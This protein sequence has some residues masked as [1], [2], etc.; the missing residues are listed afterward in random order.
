[1]P[2]VRLHPQYLFRLRGRLLESFSHPRTG[3]PWLID[4]G[5]YPTYTPFSRRASVMESR[6][7]RT[8]PYTISTLIELQLVRRFYV[9]NL[10]RR[11]RRVIPIIHV[12]SYLTRR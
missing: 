2:W 9:S 5:M 12:H 10:L 4:L 6:R 3:I 8:G 1:M 11:R 7:P